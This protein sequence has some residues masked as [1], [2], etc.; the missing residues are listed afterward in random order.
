MEEETKNIIKVEIFGSH[1]TLK[2]DADEEYV[3]KIAEYINQRLHHIADKSPDLPTFKIAMLCLVEIVDELLKTK[4]KL[5][6]IDV[7]LGDKTSELINKINS[8]LA[9]KYSF[10]TTESEGQRPKVQPST[11]SHKDSQSIKK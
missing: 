6:K 10:S 3:K 1:Y 2:T 8:Q 7:E 9:T 4:E 5:E 11:Q